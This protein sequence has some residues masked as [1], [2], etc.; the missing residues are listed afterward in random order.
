VRGPVHPQGVEPRVAEQDLG[1]GP[2]GRVALAC[3]L[4]VAGE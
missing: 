3:H 1:Q 4:D 2:R